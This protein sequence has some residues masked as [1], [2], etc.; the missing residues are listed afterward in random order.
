MASSASGGASSAGVPP[1]RRF[2][3]QIIFEVRADNLEDAR[4]KVKQVIDHGRS[5]HNGDL[6]WDWV[7]ESSS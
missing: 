1:I 6:E 7:P 3:V 5:F 2:I 4:Q